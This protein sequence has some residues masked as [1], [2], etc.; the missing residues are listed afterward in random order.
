M[1]KTIERRFP[2][3]TRTSLL[4]QAR[5]IV[6]RLE[7]DLRHPVAA[8]I[9]RTVFA[10]PRLRNFVGRELQQRDPTTAAIINLLLHDVENDLRI[11][12]RGRRHV[13]RRINTHD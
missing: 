1:A 5:E 8:P 9:A 12:R 2:P 3:S 6:D 13:K 11:E 10:T 7:P 4:R